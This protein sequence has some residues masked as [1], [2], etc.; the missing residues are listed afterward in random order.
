MPT[1]V[2]R[3]RRVCQRQP[4]LPHG[5]DQIRVGE[6]TT[7]VTFS[8]VLSLGRLHLFDL[9]PRE[10]SCHLVIA[11]Y[12]D[13]T[14]SLHSWRQCS[15]VAQ[16]TFIQST[17]SIKLSFIKTT[18]I[19][20]LRFTSTTRRRPTLACSTRFLSHRPWL[21]ISR[22]NRRQKK[23]VPFHQPPTL[24]PR[25]R[26]PLR[27]HTHNNSSFTLHIPSSLPTA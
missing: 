15:T 9:S 23:E 12:H 22:P 13:A 21:P 16:S 27:N 26:F 1:L 3:V 8:P 14:T 11:I 7:R 2:Y 4:A 24:C 17:T 6:Q 5:L 10:S 19:L 20:S 25:R 18:N